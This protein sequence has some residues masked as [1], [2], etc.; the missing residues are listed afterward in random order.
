MLRVELELGRELRMAEEVARAALA[1]VVSVGNTVLDR[2]FMYEGIFIFAVGLQLV[3][4]TN[5]FHR[6]GVF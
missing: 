5:R 3:V 1:L 2:L 4:W 6:R